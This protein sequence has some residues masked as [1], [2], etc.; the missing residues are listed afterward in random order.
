MAI[1]LA[2]SNTK[3]VHELDKTIDNCKIGEIKEEHKIP[4]ETLSAV[5]NFIH[6]RGYNGCKWCMPKYHTD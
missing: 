2:N 5:H 3:E 6:I 4:L 1:Y